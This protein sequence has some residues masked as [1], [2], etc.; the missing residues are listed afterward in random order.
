MDIDGNLLYTEPLLYPNGVEYITEDGSLLL[1]VPVRVNG[2]LTWNP[3]GTIAFY[4]P[5]INP[6]TNE[7]IYD[8][9]TG[10]P[11]FPSEYYEVPHNTLPIPTEDD[12]S[13][14]LPETEFDEPLEEDPFYS[15][16]GVETPADPFSD[17]TNETG[18]F[19]E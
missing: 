13:V 6:L 7:F 3:D 8:S 11:L 4:E 5:F 16:P 2:E 18:G 15:Q 19:P 12:F 10:L 17:I 9:A 1:K 14:L